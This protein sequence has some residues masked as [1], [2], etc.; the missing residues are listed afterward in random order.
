MILARL[1]DFGRLVSTGQSTMRVIV[2]GR[3][4]GVGFR[5]F[6][7]QT[8]RSLGVEGTVRNSSDSSVVE[9]E[10][11]G[12]RSQLELLIAALRGGPPGA[13]V[14]NVSIDWKSPPR[15]NVVGFEIV[16]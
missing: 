15:R 11:A 14:E 3:V 10:A 4:Q 12:S 13:D 7:W 9:V 5:Y 6:V 8:A 2:S 1:A 16:H